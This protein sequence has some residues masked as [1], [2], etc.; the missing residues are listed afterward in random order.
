MSLVVVLNELFLVNVVEGFNDFMLIVA[1]SK[2]AIN[3]SN[4]EYA[5]R[6]SAGATPVI[7]SVSPLVGL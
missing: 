1:L 3:F 6:F 4:K 5:K 7:C 2:Y